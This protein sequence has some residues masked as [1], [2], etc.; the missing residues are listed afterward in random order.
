MV[1]KDRKQISLVI[2]G[3]E[4]ITSMEDVAITCASGVQ[5]A[6]G[7]G[8]LAKPILYQFAIRLIKFIENKTAKTW[9]HDNIDS[10]AWQNCTSFSAPCFVLPEFDQHQRA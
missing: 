6:I 3:V 8:M 9:M 5:I 2:E 1:E 4:H 7:N 10:R